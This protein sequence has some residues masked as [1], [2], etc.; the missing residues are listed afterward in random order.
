MRLDRLIQHIDGV[1]LPAN[2]DWT[3]APGPLDV[4]SGSRWRRLAHRT[5]VADG[6]L[7]VRVGPSTS[8]VTLE[9][10]LSGVAHPHPTTLTATVEDVGS[11]GRWLLCGELTSGSSARAFTG[12]AQ[13][14][15]VYRE[16]AVPSARLTISAVLATGEPAMP[17]RRS[18]RAASIRGDLYAF[19]PAAVEQDPSVW[20]R[21]AA[22]EHATATPGAGT[23]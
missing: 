5:D 7:R 13:Y 19:A 14:H 11:R 6:V 4:A 1:E 20:S 2:G 23:I 10:S 21:S 17:L 22:R 3:L 9:L 12:A 18:A 16:G 8:L 15:G